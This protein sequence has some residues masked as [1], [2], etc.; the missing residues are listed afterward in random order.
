MNLIFNVSLDWKYSKNLS[1]GRLDSI[2]DELIPVRL[3]IKKEP[4]LLNDVF[5]WNKSSNYGY[6]EPVK[7]SQLKLN[8]YWTIIRL[9]SCCV[10]ITIFQL[11]F[12][13]RL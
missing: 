3:Y 9:P 10:M 11:T 4:Y 6:I 8:F 5:F 12:L 1:G 7:I 2:K 13:G